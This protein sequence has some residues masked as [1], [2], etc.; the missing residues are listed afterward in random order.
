MLDFLMVEKILSDFPGVKHANI[1]NRIG[2]HGQK[3][4]T[5]PY[6][7]RY[8][9]VTGFDIKPCR[10]KETSIKYKIKIIEKELT[11]SI[12]SRY[13]AVIS[14][15][16]QFHMHYAFMALDSKSYVYRSVSNRKRKN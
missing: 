4:G 2:L 15:P 9:D 8:N 13:D 1:S 10:A 11:P 6:S 14:T 3:K 5:K 16:P 7:L 12:I